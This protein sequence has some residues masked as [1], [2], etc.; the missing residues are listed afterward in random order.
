MSHRRSLSAHPLFGAMPPRVR[1]L[2]EERP[3][4]LSSDDEDELELWVASQPQPDTV[5]ALLELSEDAFWAHEAASHFLACEA[6]RD[7]LERVLKRSPAHL[8]RYVDGERVSAQDTG[9]LAQQALEA[10]HP[11]SK[12]EEALSEGESLPI[13]GATETLR[14]LARY[15]K[16]APAEVVDHLLEHIMAEE[17]SSPNPQR[18]RLSA[19]SHQML[20]YWELSPEQMREACRRLGPLDPQVWG[21]IQEPGMPRE[22]VLQTFQALADARHPKLAPKALRYLEEIPRQE[23]DPAVWELLK[24]SEDPQVLDRLFR[25]HTHPEKRAEIFHALVLHHPESAARLLLRGSHSLSDLS[26]EEFARLLAHTT[27]EQRLALIRLAPDFHQ[28]QE[29]QALSEVRTS[30]PPLTPPSARRG[31]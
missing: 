6:S 20:L 1:E 14:A 19:W 23:Q 17:E 8:C 21:R 25:L 27:G 12:Q 2:V 11:Q 31:R 10:L 29:M 28:R 3:P 13:Q 22:V 18:A 24:Q 30:E 5:L 9:W 16:G 15:R 4:I 26:R 7:L